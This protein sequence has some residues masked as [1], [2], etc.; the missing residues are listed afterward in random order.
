MEISVEAAAKNG[1]CQILSLEVSGL[2][3]VVD[4]LVPNLSVVLLN[5]S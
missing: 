3:I 4:A 1:K 2:D 5:T